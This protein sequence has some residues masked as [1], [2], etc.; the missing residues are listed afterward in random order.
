MSKTRTSIIWKI[1]DEELKKLVDTNITISGILQK[2]G[3]T[4]KGSNNSTLHKRLQ[5]SSIVCNYP[6]GLNSNKGKKFSDKHRISLEEAM[7]ENSSYGRGHL[8]KRLIREG[9]LKEICNECGQ[10]PEWKGKKLVLILDHINGISNDHRLENLQFLCPNCNSQTDTFAGKNKKYK[11]VNSVTKKTDSVNY[12]E[13]VKINYICRTC[14]EDRA[15]ESKS[16]LC[17]KCYSVSRQK[18]TRPDKSTLQ[19]EVNKLGYSAVGRK[20]NVSDNSIRKWLK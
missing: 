2:L 20:Y 1:T 18:V 17:K 5:E 10:L 15:K 9:L 7:V 6:R 12:Q 11:V 8:K 19:E 13:L 4:S 3:L 16:E 14:G